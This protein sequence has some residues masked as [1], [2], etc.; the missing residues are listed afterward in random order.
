MGIAVLFPGSW[1]AWPKRVSGSRTCRMSGEIATRAKIPMLG[2]Q[3]HHL[4]CLGRQA[5]GRRHDA[6]RQDLSE[7]LRVTP[8]VQV[9]DE[10]GFEL[11]FRYRNI[12]IGHL[13][14]APVSGIE[15]DT[16][17]GRIS[18]GSLFAMANAACEEEINGAAY[19]L[20]WHTLAIPTEHSAPSDP[21]GSPDKTSKRGCPGP[22]GFHRVWLEGCF[23]GERDS[24]PIQ[25]V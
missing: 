5:P 20:F 18:R 22:W 15:G 14:G 25:D 6:P 23:H 7:H 8:R 3:L 17:R 10:D 9:I 4:P 1:P 13:P 11:N 21:S 16:E 24:K 2:L 12:R 19:A